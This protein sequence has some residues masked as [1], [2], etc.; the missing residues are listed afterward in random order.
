MRWRPYLIGTRLSVDT[1]DD[2]VL[3][4]AKELITTRG[5]QLVKADPDR[6]EFMT[7]LLLFFFINP[8]A[9]V[10]RTIIRMENAD[11]TARLIYEL[12]HPWDVLILFAL[13]M[14]MFGGGWELTTYGTMILLY[15]P[16]HSGLLYFSH[17]EIVR[18]IAQ[19]EDRSARFL[20]DLKEPTKG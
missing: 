19:G 6:L 13:A 20:K 15:V 18:A 4:R 16:L 14:V 5:P 8:F 7:P 17:R 3:A 2:A 1:S 9:L 11:G 10:T 12:R